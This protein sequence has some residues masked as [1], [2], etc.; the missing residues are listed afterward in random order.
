MAYS[1]FRRPKLNT[2]VSSPFSPNPKLHVHSND[3]IIASVHRRL[4]VTH[5]PDLKGDFQNNVT[6]TSNN[7]SH[8]LHAAFQYHFKAKALFA[9][10][11]LQVLP[12]LQFSHV[13]G[14]IASPSERLQSKDGQEGKQGLWVVRGRVFWQGF[15]S[16]CN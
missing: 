7:H 15:F 13:G 14:S 11:F 8:F 2:L 3:L 16:D 12:F 5:T 10:L 6:A 1:R 4:N 9:Y